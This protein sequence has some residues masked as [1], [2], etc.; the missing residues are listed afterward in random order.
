MGSVFGMIE[1]RLFAI[2]EDSFKRV[3]PSA[4]DDAEI[5][6]YLGAG[7]GLAAGKVDD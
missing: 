1:R 2:R 5:E 4:E 6:I 3:R 7:R